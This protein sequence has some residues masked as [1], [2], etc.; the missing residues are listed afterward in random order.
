MGTMAC[1]IT[2]FTSVYSTVFSGADQRKHQGSVSLAFVWGIH[3]WPV[4]SPHKWPVTREIFPLDDVIISIWKKNGCWR[5]P[6]II[7][8]KVFYSFSYSTYRLRKLHLQIIWTFI[9]PIQNTITEP[10]MPFVFISCPFV[11]ELSAMD[12]NRAMCLDW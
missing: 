2:S 1:Q 10:V 7:F 4:N 9:L 8:W 12:Q 11:L 5:K 6:N 3:R